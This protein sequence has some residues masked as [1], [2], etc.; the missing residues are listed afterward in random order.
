LIAATR[1]LIPP[2]EPK[3]VKAAPGK[4]KIACGVVMSIEGRV[5]V[6]GDC[7]AAGADSVAATAKPPRIAPMRIAGA[8]RP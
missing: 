1:E 5:E 8:N 4:M 6:Q 7:A 3:G 2:P